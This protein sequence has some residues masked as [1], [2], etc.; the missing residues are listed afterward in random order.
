[1][2]ELA[3]QL[4]IMFASLIVV[5]NAAEILVPMILNY[6]ARVDNRAEVG[7]AMTAK[8]SEWPAAL[9]ARVRLSG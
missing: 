6:K 7:T 8:E 4:G 3:F 2:Y 5:N 9:N 1:M